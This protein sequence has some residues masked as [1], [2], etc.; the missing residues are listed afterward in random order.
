MLEFSQTT[1]GYKMNN[2]LSIVMAQ[3][4]ST[5]GDIIGN[6][7][8]I[9][10]QVKKAKSQYDC[11]L[12]VFPELALTGYPPEDL[13]FR[14]DLY[15]QIKEAFIHIRKASHDVAIII[16]Y[17]QKTDY[18][19]YNA[20]AFIYQDHVIDKYY[21]QILPNYGVFD[22]KRYF[23]A[24][25][26]PTVVDFK[27]TKIGLIICE[28]GWEKSPCNKA[29]K[30]GA[31]LI[32]S[33]NAS[34]FDLNKSK[35]REHIVKQRV[36]ENQLPFIYVASIGGQDELVFDGGSFAM[37]K[38]GEV[39]VHAGY[40]ETALSSVI[41]NHKIIAP[42]PLAP[43]LPDEKN[44]YQAL[45]LGIKDYV[46]K[47]GFKGAILGL[48]GGIDSALVLVLAVDALGAENVEVVLMPSRYT[49][50]MSLDDATEL[51]NNLNVKH[52]TVS[53]EPAFEIFLNML[54]DEFKDYPIDATEENIQARCRG[55]LLMA[56]SNKK[57]YL[58]L[59]TG[60]KS[61]MAV[62]Y[63]TLYGDMAGGFAPL[64][65]VP[66]T[67]VYQ[68]AKFYN[69]EK[70]NLIPERIITRPPSAELAA[71]QI[72]TDSLP[73]YDTLDIILEKYVEEDFS[74]HDI[75]A[76]GYNR[77]VVKKVLDLVDRTEYKRRQAAPGIRV[78][79]RAFGRERRYPITSKF[80]CHDRNDKE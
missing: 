8:I 27:N 24:G 41:F 39:R 5:V 59:T 16:G 37:S 34:P 14:P 78:T 20:A 69:N 56:I 51:A 79:K 28:D 49:A 2:K 57:H 42:S 66:K 36:L 12:V 22:E 74:L 65:D 4:N 58:V 72:D 55:L 38:T 73:D 45:R 19:I 75:V 21:K 13:L 29:R 44:I 17:P 70:G 71:E 10:Q 54:K 67:L 68:L 25:K 62:G 26:H 61:E 40:Y 46:S 7:D 53:I 43:P 76:L 35:Q 50:Q 63:A 64:K 30:A 77:D 9:I 32:I 48:S 6:T 52:S 31:E 47:N 33:I 11:D 60:N 15:Q 3:I 18:G 23:I 1:L 80:R